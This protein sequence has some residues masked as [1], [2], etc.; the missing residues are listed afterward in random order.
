MPRHGNTRLSRIHSPLSSPPSCAILRPDPTTQR[1]SVPGSVTAAAWLPS[2]CEAGDALKRRADGAGQRP[3]EHSRSRRALS[4]HAREAPRRVRHAVRGPRLP[5]RTSRS[6]QRPRVRSGPRTP[7]KRTSSAAN[8]R[9]TRPHR[10]CNERSIESRCGFAAE[11]VSSC[12]QRTSRTMPHEH[13][14]CSRWICGITLALEKAAALG[15]TLVCRQ[16]SHPPDGDLG[17]RSS[18]TAGWRDALRKSRG[19][20]VTFGSRFGCRM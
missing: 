1:V 6:P 15:A 11:S 2:L 4:I 8:G 10:S 14:S 19:K 9:H 5:T 12:F 13:D 18:R 7:G 17:P 20:R 3:G 16:I